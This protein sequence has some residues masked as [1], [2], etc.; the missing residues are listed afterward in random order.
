ML[1]KNNGFTSWSG[2]TKIRHR[3]DGLDCKA[4]VGFD[5]NALYLGNDVYKDT[6]YHN[7]KLTRTI[8]EIPKHVFD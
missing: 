6:I 8:L 1:C 4:I 5:A 2:V 7:N 3:S